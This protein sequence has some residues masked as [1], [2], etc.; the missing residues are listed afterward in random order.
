ML[1]TIAVYEASSEDMEIILSQTHITVSRKRALELA[2]KRCLSFLLINLNKW[3]NAAF[4]HNTSKQVSKKLPPKEPEMKVVGKRTGLW[5][6]SQ[7]GLCNSS[8]WRKTI[9]FYR[10]ATV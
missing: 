7:L 1:S 2:A 9:A 3:R 5:G 4:I 8:S 10:S 6:S